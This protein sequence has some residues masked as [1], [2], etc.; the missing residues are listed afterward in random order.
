MKKILFL[1]LLIFFSCSKEDNSGLLDQISDLQSQNSQLLS[2]INSLSSQLISEINSL[3]SQVSQIPALESQLNQALLNYENSIIN[4]EGLEEQIDLIKLNYS[5]ITFEVSNAFNKLN[6]FPFDLG[7]N[8]ST[9]FWGN[10]IDDNGDSRG[11]YM[12]EF[13]NDNLVS[14]IPFW[15]SYTESF[16]PTLNVYKWNGDCWVYIEGMSLRENGESYIEGVKVFTNSVFLSTNSFNVDAQSLGLTSGYDSL[17]VAIEFA[18]NQTSDIQYDDEAQYKASIRVYD[19]NL[20]TVFDTG[21]TD[22]N[23]GEYSDIIL[24]I[25][26]D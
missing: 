1:L 21:W 20:S 16:N 10:F 23:I 17:G 7:V 9:F 22:L 24:E 18:Q 15:T 5:Q 11:S 13:D 25:C 19:S 4:I 14:T 8:V 3:N 26:P 6:N 12:F 2:E